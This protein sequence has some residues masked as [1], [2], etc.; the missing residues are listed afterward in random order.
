MDKQ[1]L[2]DDF[3]EFL[4]LLN[5]ADVHYLLVGGYAV[6]YHGYPRATADMDIWVDKSPGNA[7]RL[8]D[9]FQ[10][11]GMQSQQLTPELFQKSD[12]IIRMGMPPV[13]IEVLTDI[14]GV[15]FADCYA[16]RISTEIDGQPVRLIARHHLRMNKQ[17]AGRYKDLDDLENLPG[18]E[19]SEE[20]RTP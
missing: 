18:D 13:R 2:P 11:F 14:D 8:V 20:P 7:A 5:D 6:G 16:S 19:G 1:T 9:V 17:A 4:R 3:K 10:Q 12:Q 15:A